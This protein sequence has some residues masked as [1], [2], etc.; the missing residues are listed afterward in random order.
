[1]KKKI[2]I[3]TLI[4]ILVAS[5]SIGLMGC[6][7]DT[8]QNLIGFDVDLA[9]AVGE[10]MGVD[11]EFKL[12]NW[13]QKEME[14]KSGTIDLLWNGM[15]ITDNRKIEFAMTQG[16]LNNAQAVVVKKSNLS[17]YTSIDVLKEKSG[18]AEGGSAGE[19][20]L[21]G[22]EAKDGKE[23]IPAI[24]KP[25]KYTKIG[26]QIEILTEL[27]AGTLDFGVMDSTLANNYVTKEGYSDLAV[28]RGFD[29]GKEEYGIAAKKGSISLIDE[30]YAQIVAIKKEGKLLE[31]AKK[32]GLEADLIVPDEFSKS[33]TTDGA[34][35]AIK[36]NKKMV[37][38]YTIFEP[39]SYEK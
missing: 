18:G 37:I 21:Q 35:D 34:L 3:V 19:I 16:Y 24:V 36:K 22:Q 25:K 15:T 23:A 33:T 30:V 9:R 38:G 5:L 7:K 13:N 8:G 20:A 27:K 1:M 39:I 12:I 10:K 6:K 32:Y 31:I 26:T 4:V 11:V 29:L 17:Q 28:V 2:L 14:I